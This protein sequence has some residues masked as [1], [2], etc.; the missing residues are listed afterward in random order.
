[1]KN[2]IHSYYPTYRLFSATVFI[3]LIFIIGFFWEVFY[4]LGLLSVTL[5]C[6]IALYDIFQI[7]FTG[8]IAASRIVPEKISNGD[9]N[10][11]TIRVISQYKKPM[12]CEIIDELP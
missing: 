7:Y 12:N 5:L 1:M 11:I 9:D 10:M 6:V 3:S 4:Y 8:K 2:L